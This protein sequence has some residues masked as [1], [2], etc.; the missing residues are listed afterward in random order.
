MNRF[1]AINFYL[2]TYTNIYSEIIDAIMNHNSKV[3]RIF[4][5]T[6]QKEID[7]LKNYLKQIK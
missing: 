4:D 5:K 6:D 2:S 7:E 1:Q 3:K